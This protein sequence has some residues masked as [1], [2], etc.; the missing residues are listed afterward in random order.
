MVNYGYMR[1]Q[2]IKLIAIGL[3]CLSSNFTIAQNAI[4]LHHSV[5]GNVYTQGGVANWATSYNSSHSANFQIIEQSYPNFPWE[6]NNYPWDYWKLWVAGGCNNADKGIAC[7]ENIAANYDLVIFKH[8]YPGADLKATALT[9]DKSVK[10]NENYKYLYRLLLAK[11]DAMPQKKFMVWTLTPERSSSSDIE[12]GNN[13]YNFVEWVKKSWLTEDGKAHP[14]VFIFD[15]F[16]LVAEG[17]ATT[18]YALKTIYEIAGEPNNN[19][20]NT[21]ANQYVGPIFAQAV[22]DIL[23]TNTSVE[24]PAAASHFSFF[25]TTNG[26]GYSFISSQTPPSQVEIIDITGNVILQRTNIQQMN[27]IWELKNHQGV[28]LIHILHKDKWYSQKI[29]L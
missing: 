15:F 9:T 28:Y 19:H 20:P 8:C 14:N 13:A 22:I 21:A 26:I 25:K 5:G 10:T 4:F 18:G 11:L 27:G 17:S 6:W 1:K 24:D 3:I 2:N 29:L 12:Q 16:N 23:K 7:L